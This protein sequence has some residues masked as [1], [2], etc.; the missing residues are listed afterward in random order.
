MSSCRSFRSMDWPAIKEFAHAVVLQMEKENP[1]LYLT[2]MR[3]AARKEGFIWTICGMSAAQLRWR[4]SL[5]GREWV[6]RF[7]FP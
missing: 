5:R 3:K 2:K 1:R 7:R 4:R 6:R